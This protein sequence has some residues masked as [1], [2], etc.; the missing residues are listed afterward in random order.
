VL[1]AVEDGNDSDGRRAILGRRGSRQAAFIHLVRQLGIPVDL[2]IASNRLAMPALG[3]MSEVENWDSL[4]LRIGTQA[5]PRWLAI[6]DKFTP[7]GYVPAE[8][9]GQPAIVLA[10]G[11]PRATLPTEGVIDGVFFEGKALVREDGG[12]SLEVVQR[13]SGRIGTQMRSVLDRIPPGQLR[14]FVETRLVGRNFS[15]ARVR[16]VSIDDKD[17][18]DKPVSIKVVADAPELVR[19]SGS[20]ASLKPVFPLKLAQLAAL[21]ER[22]TPLLLGS[23]SHAEVL[24]RVTFPD[25]WRLPSSLAPGTVKDGERTVVV[26]DRVEGHVLTLDRK[27][28]VPAGRVQPGTE[29]A[30]FVRFTLAGDALLEREVAVNR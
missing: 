9:R 19:V 12:A 3:K 30:T 22:Q 15:G 11:V 4:V 16:D 7:F 2:A 6:R 21:P 14:D 24:F 26:R 23:S 8:L 29:Y 17:D 5:G 13:Y 10:A 18:L 28:E 25:A 1:S 27:V 20:S